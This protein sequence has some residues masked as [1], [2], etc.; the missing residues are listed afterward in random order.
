M[1]NIKLDL[2][3]Y[4]PSCY[5]ISPLIKAKVYT[6][7]TTEDRGGSKGILNYKKYN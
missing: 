3:I 7:R 5:I 2:S 1:S 6:L 4:L